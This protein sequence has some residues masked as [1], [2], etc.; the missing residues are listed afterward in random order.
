MPPKGP[1]AGFIGL[2]LIWR[3]RHQPQYGY[4]LIREVHGLAIRRPP[5]S[6]LYAILNKLER[7]GYVKSKK[8]KHGQRVRRRYATTAKGWALFNRIRKGKVRGLLRQFLETL[9]G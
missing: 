9:V 8:E 5:T 7:A 1:R 2:F 4:S 6:T 3:L